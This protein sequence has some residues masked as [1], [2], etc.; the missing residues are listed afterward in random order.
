MFMLVQDVYYHLVEIIWN[1]Y[2]MFME[3]NYDV[4]CIYA[5]F[6]PSLPISVIICWIS[7]A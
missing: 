1:F 4:V 5:I 2:G 6:W 3:P 7:E